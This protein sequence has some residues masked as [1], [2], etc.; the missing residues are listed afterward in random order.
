MGDITELG[1]EIRIEY[2][3]YFAKECVENPKVSVIVPAYNVD[4]YLIQCLGSLVKQTLKEIEIIVVDDGS[5][6]C[7]YDIAHLFT[8]DRRISV[9]SQKN[10]GPSSARNRGIEIATGEYITFVDADDWIDENYLEKL[11]NSATK[12]NCDIAVSTMVRKRKSSQK[13]RM[14]FTE[15]KIYISLADKVNVCRIPVCSYACGKLYKKELVKNLKF[16]EGIYFEDVIWTPQ[17]I[18]KSNKLVTVP[19]TTYWYRVNTNSIVKKVP[20]KKKQFDS[21]S[22]KKFVIEYLSNRG[23]AF[24]KKSKTLTKEIKYF[25]GIPIYKIKEYNNIDTYYFL[26]LLPIKKDNTNLNILVFNTACMGDVLICNSLVQNIKQQ[27]P[28]SKIIFICDKKS[29]DSAVHQ[30]GVDECIVYD[31]KG[32]HKGLLGFLKFLKDFPYKKCYAAFICYKNARN[33]LIS[34]LSGARHIIQLKDKY[35][36]NYS[37]HKSITNLLKD[38]NGCSVKYLPIK[39]NFPTE[40]S[41]DLL[42]KINNKKFISFCPIT[43][44]P[45]KDIPLDTAISLIQI[46]NENNDVDIVLTGVGDRCLE[47]RDELIKNG[48]KF[49]DLVNKT[50]V[51]ELAYVL[52][53]SEV[54]I[55]ADTGTMHLGC[56]VG[57]PIVAVWYQENITDYGLDPNI[58]NSILI[59]TNQTP[60]NI[61]N[62]LKRLNTKKEVGCKC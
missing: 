13:Y 32:E 49:I 25:C 31:K 19:D 41:P 26:G 21:Y 47:Y 11:Y 20:S 59:N 53:S 42:E 61:L 34:L 14:H 12:N 46:F 36:K 56:A 39:Y 10:A 16:K 4:G 33:Y 43:S 30:Y 24:S 29:Y 44:N 18:D 2:E 3:E 27:Y 40:I 54:L 1:K 37:L 22:A 55:T 7:T 38:L 23:I 57:T 62:A 5:I 50:T 48:C 28:F 52:N 60:E 58:Y 6:D 35:A 45:L 17:A 15:E 51:P 9:Y 8:R